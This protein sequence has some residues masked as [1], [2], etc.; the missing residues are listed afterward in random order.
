MRHQVVTLATAAGLLALLLV[1]CASE[2]ACVTQLRSPLPQ[3]RFQA[4]VW[5]AR[6]GSEK[7]LPNLIDLLMDEDPS[8]RW[9]AFSALSER[10]GETLGYRP[11]DPKG[12][13][14]EATTRWK[15][16][17][18]KQQEGTVVELEAPGEAG[19]PGR[20]GEVT[21]ARDGAS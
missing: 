15:E 7:V 11:E 12:R 5:L 19:T 1:G 16:W 14:L 8:V 21:P 18:K 6:H 2:G 17:W 20:Q 9:A 3:E 4:I 13:R 10:T